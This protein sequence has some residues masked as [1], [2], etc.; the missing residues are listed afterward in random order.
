MFGPGWA[1][2]LDQALL[3]S[4]TGAR[5]VR[6]DGRAVDYPRDGDGFGRAVGENSW[7]HREPGEGPDGARLVVRDNQG[8]WWAFDPTGRW[9]ASGRGHGETTTVSR[10]GSGA[11]IRLEHEFGR[12]LEVEYVGGRVAVVRASDGRRMEYGYENGYLGRV[13]GALGTRTYRWNEDGLIAAVVSAAGVVEAENTYDEQGRVVLQ[14]S[15]YGRRTRFAYL[16]GRVTAVSDEDGTRSNSW[17]ADAKGRLV[18]MLDSADQRQSMTYDASGNLVSS[19]RRDGSVTVHAHDERG[20]RTRTV[21]AEGAD[22]TWGV[23]RAGPG[24]HLRHRVGIGHQLR[25][26]R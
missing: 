16:P 12:N 3:L 17:I 10:D 15:Q 20:R 2:V 11:V 19:T 9:L 21:T 7:L 18:G 26:P 6:D 4:D 24:D 5:W 13:T 8:G 1:S 22:L 25:V 14:V 23:R